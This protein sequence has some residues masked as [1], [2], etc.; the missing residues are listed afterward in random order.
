MANFCHNCGSQLASDS[1]FCPS[2]GISLTKN[3]Q[4]T[5][6]STPA[7]IPQHNPNAAYTTATTSVK[8][9]KKV[10]ILI[11]IVSLVLILLGVQ[12]MS[13]GIV[14][15]TA[16]AKITSARLDTRS[17]GSNLP[18]PNRYNIKYE[19]FVNGES[20]LGN[21]NQKFKYPITSTQTIQVR[22]LPNLP[23]INAS[24]KDAKVTGGL[25]L[26]G[27]GMLMF[28]LAITGKISVGGRKKVTGFS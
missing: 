2:C 1:R 22:Y 28:V 9:K 19:F 13:L 17:Y 14:G 12:N 7:P 18:D 20:Y 21:T 10:P 8:R 5:Y 16:N 23:N 24:A 27:L 3:I 26:A 25:I 11:V 6:T 15:K 4:E